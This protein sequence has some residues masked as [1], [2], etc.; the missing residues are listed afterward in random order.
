[1]K[2]SCQKKYIYAIDSLFHDYCYKTHEIEILVNKIHIC[3]SYGLPLI[4]ISIH[5]LRW[6]RDYRCM[7][8]RINSVCNYTS[9]K[10]Q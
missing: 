4:D 10:K 6:I 2:Y 8:W 7:K 3:S 5:E 1:M 9:I